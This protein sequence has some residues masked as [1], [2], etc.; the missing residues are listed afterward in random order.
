V[1]EFLALSE[2]EQKTLLKRLTH[3]ALCKMRYLTWRGAYVRNANNP[4]APG[5]YGPEDFAVDAITKLLDGRRVWNR[6]VHQTLEA[7]LKATIDSDIS[8]LVESVDNI[9]GRPLAGPTSKSETARAY[10]VPGTEP[11]PLKVVIDRDL[12]DRYH[13]AAMKELDG[14]GFLQQLFE[15]L[16]AEITAPAEIAIMLDKTVDDVN[17]GKKRLRRKLEKLDGKFAPPA[18]RPKR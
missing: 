13:T 11:N 7:A 4:V 8:H 9:N 15:C 16:E 17:N 1:D 5:G 2:E 3:H 14:D 6:E 12:Q 18:G 10:D